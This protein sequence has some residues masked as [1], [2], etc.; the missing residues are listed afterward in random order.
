MAD[1]KPQQ[2][3]SVPSDPTKPDQMEMQQGETNT[4][5]QTAPRPASPRQPLFRK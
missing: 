1:E 4:V 2:N 3:V 5:T